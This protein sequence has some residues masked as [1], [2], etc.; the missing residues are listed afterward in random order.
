MPTEGKAQVWG[1]PG[2]CKC[3]WYPRPHSIQH[4]W[5]PRS[6]SSLIMIWSLRLNFHKFCLN[7]RDEYTA[8]KREWP[9][10]VNTRV[11]SSDELP[12]WERK[13]QGCL[14]KHHVKQHMGVLWKWPW[15]EQER[16]S[17]QV[18]VRVSELLPRSRA[19]LAPR[20]PTPSLEWLLVL[21]YLHALMETA[22]NRCK[23]IPRRR[24]SGSAVYTAYMYL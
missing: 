6:A 20:Q 8:T 10:K 12:V 7:A 23:K 21:T 19:H 3:S 14:S 1:A 13:S 11:K 4:L 2:I 5:N 9:A 15:Y 16:L 24:E 22:R 18:P 17:P